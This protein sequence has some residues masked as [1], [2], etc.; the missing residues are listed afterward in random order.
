MKKLVLI[1]AA[2]FMAACSQ[3]DNGYTVSVSVSGDLTQLPNDTLI[4]TGGTR[5]SPVADTLVLADGKCTFKGQTNTP[6]SYALAFTL[7]QS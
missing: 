4:L 2:A 1:A 7:S 5:K 6:T 3:P